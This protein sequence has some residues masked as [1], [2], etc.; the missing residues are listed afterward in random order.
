MPIVFVCFYLFGIRIV[1]ASSNNLGSFA[2]V[3]RD[4]GQRD[5][6]EFGVEQAPASCPPPGSVPG[7][8][9]PAFWSSVSATRFKGQAAILPAARGMDHSNF[10]V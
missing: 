7:R 10:R 1:F 4:I 2:C 3:W 6:G 8:R 5:S 9:E